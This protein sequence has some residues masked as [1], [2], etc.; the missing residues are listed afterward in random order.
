[1][2]TSGV[3]PLTS[4]ALCAEAN[5]ALSTTPIQ[6]TAARIR[7]ASGP[8]GIEWDSTACLLLR[9]VAIW[10]MMFSFHGFFI[11]PM[12]T[13]LR[14]VVGEDKVV[15]FRWFV[16]RETS[17]VQRLAGRFA[18]LKIAEAPAARCCILFGILHHDLDID[19]GAHNE[20]LSARERRVQDLVVEL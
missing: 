4:L 10:I 16:A 3:A 11:I 2:A 8:C 14:C 9:S 12:T 7:M 18:V 17:L 6:I 15:I 1:M 20:R 5:S 19:G 13:G